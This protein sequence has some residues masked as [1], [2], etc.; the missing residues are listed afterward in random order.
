M[1]GSGVLRQAGAATA[2]VVTLACE[3]DSATLL[4]A[5]RVRSYAPDVPIIACVDLSENA[6]RVQRAG[7]DFTYSVSQVAGQLLA[8]HVLG[9]MVAQQARIKVGRLDAGALVGHHPLE[10]AIRDRTACAI[11]AV[12][13]AGEV[14]MDIPEAFILT[15]TDAVYV[16]GTVDAFNDFHEEFAPV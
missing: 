7:A 15:D 9:E 12:Q 2:R 11:V 16:C 5:T 10:S 8:Y 1:L 13:R 6:D 14:I 4:A 3:G